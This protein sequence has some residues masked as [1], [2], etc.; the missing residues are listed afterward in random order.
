MKNRTF[1]L[2]NITVNRVVNIRSEEMFKTETNNNLTVQQNG[3]QFKT[4][5][6]K[7]TRQQRRQ[8]NEIISFNQPSQVHEYVVQHLLS[9]YPSVKGIN[10]FVKDRERNVIE[11]QI[12]LSWWDKFLNKHRWNQVCQDMSRFISTRMPIGICTIKS[13]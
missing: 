3:Y 6:T 7:V 4:D 9:H 1:I 13:I 2:F 10:C 11:I 5:L 8:S 12:Q